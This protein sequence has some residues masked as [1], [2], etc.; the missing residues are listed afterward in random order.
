MLYA[1]IGKNG[2]ERLTRKFVTINLTSTCL[3]N[4]SNE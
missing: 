3:A 2:S 1:T 4:E